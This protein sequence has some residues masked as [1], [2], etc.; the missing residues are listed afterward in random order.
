MVPWLA[1]SIAFAA[2]A[3]RFRDR[4]LRVALL[5]LVPVV[6]L[7]VNRQE[8]GH[9][10][11]LRQRM[12]DEVRV[13]FDMPP[14]GLL[15]NPA[16]PSASMREMNWVKLVYL[17]KTAG[18]AWFYDDI[19]LCTHGIAG[20]RVWEF[21]PAILTVVEITGKVPAIARRHCA[22][23]RTAVP[24]SV[25]F[26]FDKPALQWELGPYEE[27]RYTVIVGDGFETFPVPRKEALYIPGV[28]A[29]DVRVRYDSPQGWTTYSPELKLDF[30]TQSDFRWQ[31]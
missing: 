12:S 31:R 30:N 23:I 25:H 4:R 2:C 10:F 9:E 5:A 19:Y 20:K 28:T 11:G 21:D 29:L 8:W 24:L 14:N 27:G 17:G 7:M 15:R 6:A 1:C 26:H 16:S 18:A 3:N 22:S 13:F